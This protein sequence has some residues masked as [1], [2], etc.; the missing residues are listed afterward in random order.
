MTDTY[1]TWNFLSADFSCVACGNR[2]GNGTGRVTFIRNPAQRAI[3]DQ[4]VI[5]GVLHE[6]DYPD[7]YVLGVGKT[8]EDAVKDAHRQIDEI[9]DLV[10]EK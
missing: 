1:K 9:D 7:L 2:F 6:D 3:W 4:I 10:I 5:S 8:F